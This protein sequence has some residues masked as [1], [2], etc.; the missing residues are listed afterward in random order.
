[1]AAQL[2]AVA[3]FARPLRRDQRTACS[4]SSGSRQ[5]AGA[6]AQRQ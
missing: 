6:C 1:M 4:V 5:G 3:A 2:S